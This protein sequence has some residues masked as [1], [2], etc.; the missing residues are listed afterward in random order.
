MLHIPGCKM[1]QSPV[2]GS[3]TWSQLH[4][5]ALR[6]GPLLDSYYSNVNN[7]ASV[8]FQAFDEKIVGHPPYAERVVESHEP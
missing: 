6:S 1:W 4:G 8:S 7:E 2:Y 5:E 3:S